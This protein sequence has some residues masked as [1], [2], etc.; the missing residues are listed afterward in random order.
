MKNWEKYQ[1]KEIQSG[2]DE[3]GNRLIS[4]F[5][6]DYK[7][8]TGNDLCASCNDFHQ[9]LIN[10]LN[11]LEKMNKVKN[12][13]FILKAIYENITL[14]GSQVYYNNA[15]L[16]DEMALELLTKHPKGEGLFEILPEDWE[17]L[18]KDKKNDGKSDD[19]IN[20]FGKEYNVDQAKD[21]FKKAGIDSRATTITGLK[22]SLEKSVAEKRDALNLLVNPV[23]GVDL[24]QRFKNRVDAVLALGFERVEDEFKLDDHVITVKEITDYTDSEFDLFIQ[25]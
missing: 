15:N 9:V 4:L 8:I 20:L 12:S 3:N 13:G 1:A 24:E 25:E 11:Q 6:K 5:A 16:T 21:L 22:N 10:F 18:V 17:N 14:H 23:L 2:S 7:F 19:T